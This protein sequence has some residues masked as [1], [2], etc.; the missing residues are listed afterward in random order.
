MKT[1]DLLP[2]HLLEPLAR[3]LDLR[4]VGRALGLSALVGAVVGLLGAGFFAALEYLQRLLLED[5]AGYTPLRAWGERFAAGA[6]PGP[7]RPLVLVVLPAAGALLAGLVTW[8]VKEARGGGGDQM[9]RAFHAGALAQPRLL[10]AKAAATLLTLGSGG[11][12]GRE[13]PTMQLGGALGALLGRALKIGPRERRVLMVAGVAAGVS[14]IFRTPLGAALLAIEVL[15]RDD[16]ESEA[17]IPAVLSSVTAYAVVTSIYGETTLLGA[18]PKHPFLARHLPLYA[19]LALVIAVAAILFLK[20]LRTTER[21]AR[22]LPVPEWARPAVGGLALG[23]FA[24]PIILFVGERLGRPGF[25]VGILGGSYGAAQTAAAGADWLP[26]GWAGV[27]LLVL[28]G[29]AKMIAA[30]LTIG[31]GGSAGDFAPSLAIGGL[32]G[33]AFGRAAALLLGDPTI[34]PGAFALVGMGAFYGGLAHVPLAALVLVSELAG[35]YD[36]LVPMMFAIGIACVALRRRTL[37]PSQPVSRSEYEGVVVPGWSGFGQRTVRELGL[38]RRPL[39]TLAPGAGAREILERAS[40]ARA[41]EVFPVVS[42][43]GALVGV[44]PAES[45]RWLVANPD[46]EGWAVAADLMQPSAVVGAGTLL[47]DAA[48]LLA[49]QGS[50]GLPVL[51]EAGLPVAVLGPTDLLAAWSAGETSEPAEAPPE[52]KLPRAG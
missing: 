9:I 52:A 43:G 25:G 42:A 12:G 49:R 14:A 11:A 8:K 46:T 24:V 3:P 4:I 40:E 1:R 48:A 2:L 17:L 5:L 36:L 33:G 19:L 31:S 30:S 50:R 27:E 39:V 44:I 6:S 13:G 37:Y 15:Y 51:D 10:W 32:F 20:T 35:S 18:L 23:L 22:R 38:E 28:L 29:F 21:I 47:S 16:F 41:Q 26:T 45:L 7:F 34:E